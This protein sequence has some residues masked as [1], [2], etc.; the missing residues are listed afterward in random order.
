MIVKKGSYVFNYEVLGGINDLRNIALK[1][2]SISVFIAIGDNWT[3]GTIYNKIK[4]YISNIA[5]IIH[6]SANIG[7]NVKIEDGTFVA[8]GVSINS[9]SKIGFMSIVN[10]N[11]S[12]DHDSQLG[13]FSS[14]GPNSV[15]GGNV[16]IGDYSAICIGS[17]ILNNISI[18]DHT[19]LGAN[20]LLNDNCKGNL[21]LYGNPAKIIRNREKTD[22][23][24]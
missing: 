14:L 6:P 5:K 7:K 17:T 20:S 9:D 2:L 22:G 8:P 1:D 16:N 4:N 10:T 24:L 3:R 19:V 23:Y 15:T 12:I 13:E 21:V 11:S 18:G